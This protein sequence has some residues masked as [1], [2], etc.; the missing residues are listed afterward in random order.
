LGVQEKF[1]NPLRD[2]T[3]NTLKDVEE[4]AL[5]LRDAWELGLAPIS[6]LL[7]ILEE[8]VIRVHEVQNIDDFDGLSARVGDFHVIVIK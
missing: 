5:K 7:E 1:S 6:N 4:A 3:I 2:F 8:N